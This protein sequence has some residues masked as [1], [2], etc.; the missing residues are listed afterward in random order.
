LNINYDEAEAVITALKQGEGSKEQILIVIT[1]PLSWSNTPGKAD[2]TPFTDKE[3]GRR[4][5][6]PKY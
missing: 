1:S 5:P 2:G 3:F 4:V 6:L